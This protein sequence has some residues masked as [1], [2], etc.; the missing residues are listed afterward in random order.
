MIMCNQLCVLEAPLLVEPLLLNLLL[1]MM[2]FGR[3]LCGSSP[4]LCDLSEELATT[5][6]LS[7]YR[8]N[9]S[10]RSRR[11]RGRNLRCA[12]PFSHFHAS[13]C[14]T[15]ES[16]RNGLWQCSSVNLQLRLACRLLATARSSASAERLACSPCS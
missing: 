16:K 15:P 10:N 4:L 5:S 1:L 7:L 11:Q 9:F 2:L 12:I 8:A 6:S 13:A 3:R 14:K